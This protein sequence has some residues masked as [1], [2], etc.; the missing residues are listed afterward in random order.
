MRFLPDCHARRRR[1]R[2]NRDYSLW[3]RTVL[4]R[5]D[6]APGATT[7]G[8]NCRRRLSSVAR[9]LS[10]RLDREPRQTGERPACRTHRCLR[11]SV[12]ECCVPCNA[13]MPWSHLYFYFDLYH[14]AVRGPALTRSRPRS[15]DARELSVEMASVRIPIAGAVQ[16]ARGLA[17]STARDVAGIVRSARQK[18][19][20]SNT[21]MAHRSSSTPKRLAETARRR[22]K[23][24]ALQRRRALSFARC[25]LADAMSFG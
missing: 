12:S 24:R 17:T 25:L 21:P 9:P 15:G 4:R 10:I 5:R 13:G 3:K 20:A 6:Q 11:H 7:G 19:C 8:A 18:P 14:S 16:S 23:K 2:F 1:C 22:H